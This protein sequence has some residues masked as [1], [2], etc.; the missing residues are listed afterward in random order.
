MARMTKETA[1]NLAIRHGIDLAT[2]FHAKSSDEVESI[3]EAMKEV[4]YRAPRNRMG[5]R[6]RYFFAYMQRA[7]AKQD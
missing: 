6:A 3:V 1:W 5:S 2:D 7:Y 4:R